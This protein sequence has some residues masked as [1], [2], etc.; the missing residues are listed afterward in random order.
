MVD[1]GGF[2]GKNG[3]QYNTE[4]GYIIHNYV[5]IRMQSPETMGVFVQTVQYEE[6]ADV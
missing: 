3:I 6:H 5:F 2:S 1:Y 4:I